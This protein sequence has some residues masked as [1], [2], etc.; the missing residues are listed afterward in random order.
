MVEFCPIFAAERDPGPTFAQHWSAFGPDSARNAADLV[1]FGPSSVERPNIYPKLVSK[2]GRM[3]STLG[4]SPPAVRNRK[5]PH[6]PLHLARARREAPALARAHAGTGARRRGSGRR[7]R[8]APPWRLRCRPR[9]RSRSLAPRRARAR[10]GVG[11]YLCVQPPHRRERRP[12]G[13]WRACGGQVAGRWRAG[14]AGL[15]GGGTWCSAAESGCARAQAGGRE[16]VRR[17]RAVG[18]GVAWRLGGQRD[19]H[20]A[21]L[22][23]RAGHRR[24]E[25]GGRASAGRPRPRPPTSEQRVARRASAWPGGRRRPAARRA[26]AWWTPGRPSSTRGGVWW[27]GG[28]RRASRGRARG[29]RAHG[30]RHSMRVQ[31]AALH[32]S[33]LP[34]QQPHAAHPKKRSQHSAQAFPH[35]GGDREHLQ[36][37]W[38]SQRSG[39]ARRRTAALWVRPMCPSRGS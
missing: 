7:R 24:A 36:P 16:S 32:P 31:A 9:G 1:E 33:E 13:W 3:W 10:S 30:V 12:A 34:Q 27:P 17:R 21:A 14:G 5:T 8:N 29:R 26:S 11:A 38:P 37:F 18:R 20:M 25:C 2:L 15:G 35:A 19:G 6:Q 22:C 39:L 28:Q 23:G 4:R